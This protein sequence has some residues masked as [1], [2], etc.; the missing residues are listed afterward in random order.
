LR[1]R[2]ITDQDA[3]GAPRVVV[4]NQTLAQRYF[5]QEDPLGK[6]IQ[7]ST[8][9]PALG[10]N[11]PED[12]ARE[13]VGIVGDL[14]NL[15]FRNDRP[16]VMYG[17]F[18]QSAP[19][20][21][22]QDHLS[23]LRKNLVIRTSVSPLSLAGPVR[24]VVRQV[25]SDQAAQSIKTL[26]QHLVDSLALNRFVMGLFGAFAGLAVLLATVGLYG[27]I[28]HFVSQRTHE[29]GIRM[30]LGARKSDVLRMVIKQILTPTMI[31]LTI[32]MAASLTLQLALSRFVF[33]LN[34][35]TPVTYLAIALFMTGVALLACVYPARAATRVD[36]AVAL[37]YE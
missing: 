14:D 1:G 20:A 30:A 2:P 17:S 9:N 18:R 35:S 22:G 28:S 23:P 26:N 8:R 36:P 34:A 16:A 11:P 3:E 12:P 13:I 33:G 4:I 25:D 29:F 37:R 7:I 19:D 6:V 21:R 27:V 32:G 5:P 31:G 15:V 10:M 24:E